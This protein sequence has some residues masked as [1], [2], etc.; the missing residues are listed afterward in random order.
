MSDNLTTGVVSVFLA[1]IGVATLAVILAPKSQAPGV[2]QAGTAGV[3]LDL[4]AATS[5]YGSSP[6]INFPA[7][8]TS[9]F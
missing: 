4:E 8:S 3:A 7:A 9:A 2:I 1:I 5:P 6:T